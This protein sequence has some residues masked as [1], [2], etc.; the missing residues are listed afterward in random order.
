MSRRQWALV[1]V[2]V[3]IN[4]IVF[5]ALADSIHLQGRLV[6]VDDA[7]LDFGDWENYRDYVER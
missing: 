3:L 7:G 2:L 5:V 6:G 4:Y 1:A